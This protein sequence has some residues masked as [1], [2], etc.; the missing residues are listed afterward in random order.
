MQSLLQKTLQRMTLLLCLGIPLAVAAR[1]PLVPGADL[2][3]RAQEVVAAPQDT[4]L[5]IARRYDLGFNE[6][7]A[8]NPGLDPWLPGAGTRVVLPTQFI[9]PEGPR[10]GIVVNLAAMRLFY[11]PAPGAG[12][13]PEVVTFPIG[14]GRMGWNTPL[15]TTRIASKVADP[16][17][18]VPPSIREEHEKEG[19]ALP[20]SVPAGPD[21]PLGDFA[22]MLDLPGY[23]IHGTNKPYGVGRRVSHGCI[24]LY[25]EDIADL[26]RQVSTGLPVRFVDQPDVA[27]WLDGRLYLQAHAPLAGDAGS[28]A[29]LTAVVEA[30]LTQAHRVPGTAVDWDLALRIA[31]EGRLLPTAVSVPAAS[32]PGPAP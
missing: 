31:R 19:D 25:P 30:V 16:V 20:E 28:A 26:F 3:G 7:T 14:I 1:F 6:I 12:E 13:S 8:A 4:L 27:G 21:N 10:R 15:V 5:D 2:V 32:R 23:L 17:W 9:L 11:F 18:H 29:H 24:R 22:L